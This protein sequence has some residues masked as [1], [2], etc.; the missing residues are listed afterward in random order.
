MAMSTADTMSDWMEKKADY[1]FAKE[2]ERA[3]AQA[4]PIPGKSKSKEF[5]YTNIRLEVEGSADTNEAALAQAAANQG[6]R[7]SDVLAAKM[8]YKQPSPQIMYVPVPVP[9]GGFVSGPS[10]TTPTPSTGG[11]EES[12]FLLDSDNT[13]TTTTG[14]TTPPFTVSSSSADRSMPN[15]RRSLLGKNNR[16]WDA[17]LLFTEV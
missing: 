10:G 3:A 8:G 17:G 16:G 7:I 1:N 6:P 2:E 5:S 13:S 12:P 11:G 15:R 14:T 9:S 4:I